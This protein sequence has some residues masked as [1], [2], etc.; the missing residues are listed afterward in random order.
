MSLAV[1]PVL[2]PPSLLGHCAL[3]EYRLSLATRGVQSLTE[4]D[5]A[6]LRVE[7]M[8]DTDRIRDVEIPLLVG[9]PDAVHVVHELEV[10]RLS[11]P[12]LPPVGRH[13]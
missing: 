8:A 7:P 9:Q 2:C 4:H 6:R 3:Q 5:R 11:G 1:L 13:L 10:R 12:A